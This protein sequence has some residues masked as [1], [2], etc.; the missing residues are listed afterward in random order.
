[1]PGIFFCPSRGEARWREGT[2]KGR[3]SGNR[4]AR[5][6]GLPEFLGGFSRYHPADS[7][8]MFSD[9]SSLWENRLSGLLWFLYLEI[10]FYLKRLN[11]ACVSLL[12]ERYAGSCF[13]QPLLNGRSQM[14]TYLS[15][16]LKRKIRRGKCCISICMLKHFKKWFLLMDK[17]WFYFKFCWP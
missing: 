13:I 1:M 17:R 11:N 12:N 15:S 4:T 8:V 2:G 5:G 16:S 14:M 3:I 7:W 9:V 10:Y 6:D